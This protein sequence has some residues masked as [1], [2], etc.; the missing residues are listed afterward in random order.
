M[1]RVLVTGARGMLGR[2]VVDAFAA[3]HLVRATTRDGRDGTQALD[4]GDRGAVLDAVRDFRP[5]WI[6][7][8]AAYTAVDQAESEEA[9]AFRYNADAPAFLA[10]AAAE[11][12]GVLLHVST[13]FVFRGDREGSY[14]ETDPVGPVS[15]YA[16]SKE[17]GERRV[18]EIFGDHLILR[19]SWLFG[20]D[21]RNFVD[22][23]VRLA[24]ERERLR[25]V[26]D[27]RGTP[28]STVDAAD[29]ALRALTAGLRGTVHGANLG[30]TTWCA[31]ARE[32][33]RLA[34][35]ATPVDAIRTEDYPTP[36]TR[37]RNSALEDAVLARELGFEP[38][39][40]TVAL[41]EHF[42]RP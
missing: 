26:D 1:A 29:V 24:R 34:G 25:V 28:T 36:A 11:T 31:F 42:E 5:D 37:P 15:V 18:R 21:G 35:I 22:T 41:A 39:P 12:G 20:R 30:A 16:R 7:N 40:W 3:G 13:D 27:Q 23:I 38:R 4:V 14:V 9:K 2:R 6:I 10:E 32:A 19:I 17:A 33:V 8:A